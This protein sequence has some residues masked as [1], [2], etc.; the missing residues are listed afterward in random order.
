MKKVIFCVIICL[1]FLSGCSLMMNTPT[2]KVEE[3]LA[4]YQSVDDAVKTD[5][6]STVNSQTLTATQQTNYYNII[7]KQFKNLTYTVKDEIVDGGTAKVKVEIE[8]VDYKKVLDTLDQEYANRTDWTDTQYTD[9]KINRLN[10]ANEK[11]KYTL[12]INVTKDKSGSWME[13]T[14]TDV[15]RKKILGMY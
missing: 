9:E 11:V 2:K 7:E 3:L 12:E 4:K 10:S 1:S 6:N 8:V 13:P 15:D 5:I 14:L